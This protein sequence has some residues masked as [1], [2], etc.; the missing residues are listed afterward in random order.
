MVPKQEPTVPVESPNQSQ[1]A[2]LQRARISLRDTLTRYT[3]YSRSTRS[4]PLPLELQAVIKA[5]SARLAATL[6]KLEQGVIRIAV[7][8]LVSRGKSAVL[9]ALMGQ[10]VLLTGPLHGVTQWPR[11]MHWVPPGA[12]GKVQIELIDMPGLDEI[13]GQSRAEMAYE[14]SQ[15]ADLILFVVAG[16]ITRTEYQALCKLQ[17]AQ[18]PLLLVFNKI[19]L[20]P[21]RDRQAIYKNLQAFLANKSAGPALQTLISAQEV[22]LVAAEPAPLQV[23]VEWPDGRVTQEWE[24]IPPQ[25]D[26]LKQRILGLLNQE[27][28]ALL[29]LNAM[30]QAREAEKTIAQHAFRFQQTEADELIWKFARAKALAV[31]I[32]PV[33]FLDLFGGFLAD[34]SLIRALARLYGLPMTSYEASKLWKTILTQSGLL[35]LSEWGSSLLLGAGRTGALLGAIGSGEFTELFLGQLA[36]GAAQGAV[37]GYGTYAIGRAA[38]AYLER[39]CT[40]GTDGPDTV[41]RD[42]LKHLDRHT[43]LYRLRQEFGRSFLS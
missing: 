2:Q 23:R 19:D 18:K 14:V 40:W 22:V 25:V 33:I 26:E 29:S 7:F 10:K 1:A 38:Q 39:G 31:G 36:I 21:D 30:I 11:S 42:I 13:D 5:E 43:I 4:R 32:N 12:N 35:L 27:G 41:I 8:G 9:N 15:Q 6:E 17:E 28:Q 24:P 37:A 16:D 3:Q 20:Y 34:L